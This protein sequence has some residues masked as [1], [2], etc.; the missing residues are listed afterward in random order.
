MF[1][2]CVL[3]LSV[4]EGM[5]KIALNFFLPPF[6]VKAIFPYQDFF[7]SSFT[8]MYLKVVSFF[9]SIQN[10]M[11]FVK[12]HNSELSKFLEALFKDDFSYGYYFNC[13]TF[14]LGETE[15]LNWISILSARLRSSESLFLSL[16]SF[17]SSLG[18]SP[19]FIL[20]ILTDAV[21]SRIDTVENKSRM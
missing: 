4:M 3:A 5:S 11:R 1:K 12:L 16:D 7:F 19:R 18:D 2:L 20:Y 14:F 9:N 10:K 21:K 15:T 6:I 17:L 13:F 8:R